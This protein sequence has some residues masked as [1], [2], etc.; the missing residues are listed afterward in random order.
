MLLNKSN[1][2]SKR[3]RLKAEAIET[4]AIH[5]TEFGDTCL[6]EI[7]SERILMFVLFWISI[8]LHNINATKFS[9][10]GT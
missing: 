2:I 8:V 4:M 5:I 1:D 10:T 6:Q 3:H 9:E 7:N